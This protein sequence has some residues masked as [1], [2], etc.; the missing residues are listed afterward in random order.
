MFD[1]G[2]E[3][4]ETR[5]CRLGNAPGRAGRSS[6]GDHDLDLAAVGADV[7]G[8]GTQGGLFVRGQQQARSRLGRAAG[9]DRTDAPGGIGDDHDLLAQRLEPNSHWRLLHKTTSVE[10]RPEGCLANGSAG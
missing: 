1:P 7:L 9:E 5:Q 6:V 2:V 10:M 4:A 8:E 3:A